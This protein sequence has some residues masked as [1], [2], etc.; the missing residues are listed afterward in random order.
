MASVIGLPV[1][2]L[3]LS[4]LCSL[5]VTF[6]NLVRH[7][8]IQTEVN[9]NLEFFLD[10]VDRDYVK[11]KHKALQK[12]SDH[13]QIIHDCYFYF[14]LPLDDYEAKVDALSHVDEYLIK[15]HE[16]IKKTT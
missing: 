13:I 4:I 7:T 6:F 10:G 1:L 9:C 2:C 12:S 8:L 16:D 11:E 15:I 5:L 3:S 14:R